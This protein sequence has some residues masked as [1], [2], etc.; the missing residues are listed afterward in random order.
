M[1]YIIK[2]KKNQLCIYAGFFYCAFK[3]SI[4]IQ[5]RCK[6]EFCKLKWE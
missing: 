6:F 1:D 5:N 2:N 4:E 3:L